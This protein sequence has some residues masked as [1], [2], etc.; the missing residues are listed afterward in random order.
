MILQSKKPA[1][2]NDRTIMSSSRLEVIVPEREYLDEDEDLLWD[3]DDDDDDDDDT[4][5]T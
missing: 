3:D 4:D 5:D 1:S 2:K